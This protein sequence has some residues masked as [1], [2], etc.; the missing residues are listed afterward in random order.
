MWTL[1]KTVTY[2]SCLLKFLINI[3]VIDTSLHD[4]SVFNQFSSHFWS[5]VLLWF[6]NCWAFLIIQSLLVVIQSNG[7]L[8]NLKTWNQSTLTISARRSIPLAVVVKCWSKAKVE[9]EILYS[10][11]G[12]LLQ[13]NTTAALSMVHWSRLSVRASSEAEEVVFLSRNPTRT[14]LYELINTVLQLT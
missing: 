3:T 6:H 12:G 10:G 1:N 2:F 5:T 7:N 11:T 8:K 9:V 13:A 4:Y 14:P